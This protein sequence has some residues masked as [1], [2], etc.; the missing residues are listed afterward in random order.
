M[1]IPLVDLKAQ[2]HSIKPEIDAAV[3]RIFENTSFI[4]GSEVETFEQAMAKYCE[5]EHAVG[6]SSG[7]A[8]LQM[9]LMAYNIG[10]GDEVIT[11][12][13]T[14]IA[15]AAAISHVGARPVLVDADKRTCNIDPAKIEEAIT[16]RT[17]A[18]LPVTSPERTACG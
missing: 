11:T 15:T 8:A 1:A 14:F 9:T 7:T 12:P 10:K 17:K 6:V 13:A 3:S 4:L 2:Y 5:T 18:I 16:P